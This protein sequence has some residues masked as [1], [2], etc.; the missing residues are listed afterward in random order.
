MPREW[1]FVEAGLDFGMLGVFASPDKQLYDKLVNKG[2]TS[3]STKKSLALT[4][5][6]LRNKIS[7]SILYTCGGLFMTR[8]TANLTKDVAMANTNLVKMEI[9][10]PQMKT[11]Q[12]YH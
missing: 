7:I 1:S 2:N 9:L 4:T 3:E 10:S 5:F 6:V 11:P 8:I 12:H